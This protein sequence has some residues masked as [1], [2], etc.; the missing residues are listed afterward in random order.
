MRNRI[1]VLGGVVLLL[2]V[3]WSGAW[4]YFAGQIRQQ[5]D[6]LALADGETTPQL[7][8]GTLTVSGYPFHFDAD[9]TEAV[10]VSADLLVTIPAIR[11]Q[12]LAYRPNHILASV[13][14]PAELEDAF[15]GARNEI[16]WTELDASIRLEN[17]RIG[18]VSLEGDG[19][20]WRD[21][22]FGDALIAEVPRFEGHLLDMP[23]LHN[24]ETGRAGLAAYLRGEDIAI[25]AF[26]VAQTNAE[27]E[28]EVS[29]LLDD[30]RDWGLV[31]FLPDWQQAGGRLR[32]VGLRANDGSADLNA[33][34]DLALDDQGFPT[35]SIAVDSL[36]VAERIGPLIEEPWRTLVLGLPGEDGR[37]VNQLSFANGGLNSGF[38]PIA[39]LPSLF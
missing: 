8:C 30:I 17:W 33:T 39:A 9:C 23:E 28:A 18:R 20:S 7:R 19:L 34:G 29:G 12:A 15:T 14:G 25:P 11:A 21:T 6:V 1:I 36:G 16:S 27:L 31:P 22:L 5:I 32:V 24:E 13:E 38:V 10:L 2:V 3:A 35:G 4:L 37:H 26:A